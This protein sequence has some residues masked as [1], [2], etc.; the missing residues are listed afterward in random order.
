MPCISVLTADWAP[1]AR[2]TAAWSIPESAMEKPITVPNSPSATS[3]SE[4]EPS[5]SILA[6]SLSR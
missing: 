1:S 3:H 5:H 2:V 4:T 6:K